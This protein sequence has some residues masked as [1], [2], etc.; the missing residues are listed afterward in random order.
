MADA[1]CNADGCLQCL[2]MVLCRATGEGGLRPCGTCCSGWRCHVRQQPLQQQQY[3]LLLIAC[4]DGNL[5]VPC[6]ITEKSD[7]CSAVH[8]R[9]TTYSICMRVPVVQLCASLGR[10]AHVVPGWGSSV[11]VHLSGALRSVER[12]WRCVAAVMQGCCAWPRVLLPLTWC[13]WRLGAG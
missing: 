5:L 4:R 13:G 7:F 12:C 2:L 11:V 3:L 1:R 10:S 6:S 8:C 9:S